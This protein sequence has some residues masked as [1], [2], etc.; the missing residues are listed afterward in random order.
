MTTTVAHMKDPKTPDDVYIGRP[1]K[2]GN[3]FSHQHGTLAAFKVKNRD[4]AVRSY[5]AHI[6]AQPQLVAAAKRELK[7]KRLVC[8]C[9]PLLC[10]GDVLAKIA[11]EA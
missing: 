9:R 3:P 11:E 8:W 7:G 6:R 10:H 4:T 2:W 1:S 5:E